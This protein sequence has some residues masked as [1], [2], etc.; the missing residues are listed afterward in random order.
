MNK[1]IESEA[2]EMP[3]SYKDIVQLNCFTVKRDRPP[4]CLMEKLQGIFSQ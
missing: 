4:R 3:M 2:R 1:N